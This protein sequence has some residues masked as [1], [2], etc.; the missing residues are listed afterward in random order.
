MT[1]ILWRTCFVGAVVGMKWYPQTVFLNM[2]RKL[3]ARY[4]FDDKEIPI[5][6]DIQQRIEKVMDDLKLSEINR[7][8]IKFFNVHDVDVYHAGLT[9]AKRGAIIG[10]PA[11]FEYENVESITDQTISLQYVSIDWNTEPAKQFRDS[12]VLS[13]N[14]QK[15]AIALK[16]LTVMYT[17]IELFGSYVLDGLVA[18]AIHDAA[19]LYL[20]ISK[21]Q[22]LK[23]ASLW[24]VILFGTYILMSTTDRLIDNSIATKI[25]STLTALGSDY[26]QGGVEYYEKLSK[27]NKA[28]RILLGERGKY[29]FTPDGN[30][31]SWII[32]KSAPISQ[33]LNY[34]SQNLQS[35]GLHRA[36][37]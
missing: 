13:E 25:N 3:R 22:R 10:I 26:I 4:G 24:G 21:N 15:F 23:Y 35:M 8:A 37:I 19:V 32:N 9:K 27:R 14:A 18:V 1:S 34:F 36:D 29:L 33:Q 11:N 7:K 17:S 28:L 6:E 30:E 16:I 12:L 2:R 31:F 20:N 5:Q